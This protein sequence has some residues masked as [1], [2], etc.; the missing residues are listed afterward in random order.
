MLLGAARSRGIVL[1]DSWMIGDSDIDIE[2]GRNAGCKTVRLSANHEAVG[3]V[4]RG[5]PAASDADI[6]A[7]SLLDAIHQILH[8]ERVA[9]DSF[10]TAPAAT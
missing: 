7:P 2:A 9:A 4:G 10:S 3:K 5:S 1:R 6:L 8:R